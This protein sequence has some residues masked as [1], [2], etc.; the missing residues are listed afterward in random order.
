MISIMVLRVI[1]EAF[2]ILPRAV[3]DPVSRL[4]ARSELDAGHVGIS[5]VPVA[6]SARYGAESS[7]VKRMLDEMIMWSVMELTI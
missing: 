7:E 6:G 5:G 2:G 3:N 4:Q 1:A